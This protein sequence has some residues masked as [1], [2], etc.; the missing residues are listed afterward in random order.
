MRSEKFGHILKVTGDFLANSLRAVLKGEFLL[1]LNA[2]RYFIHIVYTFLL[3]WVAIWISLMI[4]TS[5]MKVEKN[6]E[7]IREMEIAYAEK[8]FELARLGRRSTVART[9]EQMGSSV[10]EPEVPAMTVEK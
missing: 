6:K 7:T 9:L 1:R 10:S 5:L 3:F 4:D 2:G 8:A